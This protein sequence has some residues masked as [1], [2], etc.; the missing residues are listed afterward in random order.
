MTSIA[1]SQ[2]QQE[3]ELEQVLIPVSLCNDLYSYPRSD[4]VTTSCKMRL[5]FGGEKHRAIR[6]DEVSYPP[7]VSQTRFLGQTLAEARFIDSLRDCLE[8]TSHF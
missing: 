6:H 1:A 7:D 4:R 5:G 2:N 8:V 3:Q